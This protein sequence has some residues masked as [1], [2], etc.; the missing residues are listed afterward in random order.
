MNE[1]AME[2]IRMIKELPLKTAKE[3][4]ECIDKL[5]GLDFFDEVMNECLNNSQST[6]ARNN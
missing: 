5:F 4:S 1:Q 2:T 6:T 3:Q